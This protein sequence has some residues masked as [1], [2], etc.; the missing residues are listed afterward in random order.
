LKPSFTESIPLLVEIRM[1]HCIYEIFILLL[2]LSFLPEVTGATDIPAVVGGV[3]LKADSISHD[4]EKEQ[5]QAKGNVE[6]TWDGFT[7][8]SDTL[9]VRQKNNEAVAEGNV[10]LRK[11]G[12]ELTGDRVTVNYVTQ[13]G[14]VDNGSLFVRER[15]FYVRGKRFIKTGKDEY[16][17]EN[18]TFTTCDGDSPSWKFAVKDLDVTV[19]GYATGT[20]AIFYVGS[21]PLFY[22]PYIIF[23]VKRERQ[24][25][26]LAPR[27][28]TSTKKGIN[29][30]IPYYWAISPSQE[31]TFDLD[32][33]QKRGV[34]IGAD[35]HYLR[36]RGSSGQVKEYLIYDTQKNWVRGDLTIK[37]QEIFTPDLMLTSD[38]ILALDRD[39]YRDYG[40]NSG[41]YNRQLLDS[42]IFLTKNWIQNSLTVETR[43][44][45]DLDAST[46]TKTMQKL[47]AVTFTRTGSPLGK[48][49]VNFRLDSSFTDF[50]RE[51]GVR[52]QR[53]DLHPALAVYRSFIPGI[54]FSA[55]GGY[56]QRL[57]NAYGAQQGSGYHG[58]G[59]FDAGATFAVPL[60]RVFKSDRGDL[61]A[62]RH[63]LIPE[64]GYRLV[65]DKD[66]ERLPFFDY[67]DRILGQQMLIWSL[68]NFVTGKYADTAGEPAYRDILYLRLSQTYQ[69]SGSRR[70]LLS[71]VDDG[72]R[73]TDLRL[74]ARYALAR[75]L[76]ADFDTRYN[77]N[78]TRFSTASFG[79]NFD[80]R[81]GDLASLGYHYAHDQ[82]NY[83]EGKTSLALVKPLVL[84]Y[85]CRYS[86]DKGNFLESYVSLEFKRQCWSM[87]FSYRDRTDNREFMLNFTLA[88]IGA[89]GPLKTF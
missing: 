26:F 13:Q 8:L 68:T 60:A 22:T 73:F 52:G 47:P 85:T 56:R 44:V 6:A 35:Y 23:P 65:Q 61:T 25:G 74:E 38:L 84:N 11:D 51:E 18:G 9:L 4:N 79:F 45:E 59:V 16:R 1:K 58:D 42:T 72:Y 89:F 17:L 32:A 20:H 37:Q 53:L 86:F 15:N 76:T 2:V 67:G 12:A 33:Q 31:V 54:D 30:D 62:Y 57:Y 48:I 14:E 40:E 82:V 29:L 66:Q 64:F 27:F 50:Y 39:F 75:L 49:P 43:Y 77:P 34:G 36:P 19:E 81:K 55:W 41:D 5:F 69:L 83:L 7:L 10:T 46:N 21:M 63:T 24:S 88:G 87:T 80:D 3:G 71:L 28:G 70:D 78:R